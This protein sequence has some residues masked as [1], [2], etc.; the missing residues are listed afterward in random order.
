MI[1]YDDLVAAL[2]TWRARQGLSVAQGAGAAAPA[3]SPSGRAPAPAART[4]QPRARTAPPVARTAPPAAPPRP[5]APPPPAATPAP[6]PPSNLDEFDGEG[7]DFA[8]AFNGMLVDQTGEATAIGGAPE[9]TTEN[10][11]VVKRGKPNPD[12]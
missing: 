12:W 6:R 10:L 4:A 8:V 7:E 1:P 3:Q 5:A 9:P 11:P 2:A